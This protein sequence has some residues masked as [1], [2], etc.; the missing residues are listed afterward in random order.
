MLWLSSK[1]RAIEI[2]ERSMKWEYS[3]L[4]F[5]PIFCPVKYSSLIDSLL[6]I[7]IVSISLPFE[8]KTWPH[9]QQES[10]AGDVHCMEMHGKARIWWTAGSTGLTQQCLIHNVSTAQQGILFICLE[11]PINLRCHLEVGKHP[12]CAWRR[13]EAKEKADIKERCLTRHKSIEALPVPIKYM[14]NAHFGGCKKFASSF[15]LGLLESWNDPT[16]SSKV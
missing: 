13:Q 15:P 4:V 2:Q 10:P 6:T 11:A 14:H 7:S 5:P 12:S 9:L 8:L 1:E 16:G 3:H